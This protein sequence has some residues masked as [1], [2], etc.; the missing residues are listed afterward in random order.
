MQIFTS[1]GF[2]VVPDGYMTFY[3]GDKLPYL[4]AAR[5]TEGWAVFQIFRFE[6]VTWKSSDPAVVEISTAEIPQWDGR[7]IWMQQV[8]A[9]KA[10]QPGRAAI[11]AT[12]TAGLV[13]SAFFHILDAESAPDLAVRSQTDRPDD[14]TGPQIHAVYVIPKDGTDD[15][16][17]LDGTIATSIMAT[18]SWVARESGRMLRIDTHEGAPDVTFLR[19]DQ[20][21]EDVFETRFDF[22]NLARQSG[23]HGESPDKTYLMYYVHDSVPTIGAFAYFGETMAVVSARGPSAFTPSPDAY[24]EQ[25]VT[26]AHELFHTFGAVDPCAPNWVEGNHVS[27]DHDVMGTVGPRLVRNIRIDPG[28]DDYYGHGRSNCRDTAE[29]PFWEL[30]PEAERPA[31]RAVAFHGGPHVTIECHGV[32]RR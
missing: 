24:G 4:D 15:Q 1:P 8:I 26:A 18:R 22:I 30:I 5:E 31:A 10:L 14:I 32:I 2:G 27:D 20:D 25:E 6:D 9:P 29:S 28:R 19:L 16:L 13:D 17:D 11:T 3:L 23:F 7:E 21:H 12:T